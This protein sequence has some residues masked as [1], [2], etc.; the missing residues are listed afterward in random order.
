MVEFF[1]HNTLELLGDFLLRG[2]NASLGKQS[3]QIEVLGL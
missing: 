2:I 1:H 3:A